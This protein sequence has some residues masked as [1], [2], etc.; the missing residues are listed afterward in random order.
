MVH[1]YLAT[2][3]RYLNRFQ[4]SPQKNQDRNM[5]LYLPELW[6]EGGGGSYFTI[7]LFTISVISSM[8]CTYMCL[9]TEYNKG[10]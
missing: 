9:H 1:S 8:T 2:G 5:I 6:E 4:T 3:G 7:L 10:K